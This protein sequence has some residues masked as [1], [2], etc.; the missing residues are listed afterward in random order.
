MRTKNRHN[1]LPGVLF[2]LTLL[3][4][5]IAQIH[6]QALTMPKNTFEVQ[7]PEPSQTPSPSVSEWTYQE[8]IKEGLALIEKN[9]PVLKVGV[10]DIIFY[11]RRIIQ[12]NGLVSIAKKQMHEPERD[13]ALV[14]LNTG[15][16]KLN[17]ITINE[18]GDKLS[19]PPGYKIAFVERTNGIKKNVWNTQRT[20]IEPSDTIVLLNVW[21][22]FVTKTVP[23]SIKTK[24]GKTK[25]IYET[26]KT[27]ENVVYSPYGDGLHVPEL[28]E[29]GREHRASD[30]QTAFDF[31]RKRGVMS[32]AFP[33]K[34]LA[35]VDVL[36]PE[37]FERLP[38]LEQT[39]Y[40]EFL[41]DP[42]KAL[43]R[44]DVIIGANGDNAYAPSCSHA[45]ACGYVQFTRGTYMAMDRKYPSARLMKDFETGAGDHI[46][47]TMAAILLFDY[48][49]VGY[50]DEFGQSILNDPDQLEEILD[51]SYNG[52]PVHAHRS[53]NA[54]ILQGLD[55]WITKYLRPETKGY[56]VKL[57]YIRDNY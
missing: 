5:L 45:G 39:D 32:R 27:V 24:N 9:K 14:L 22:H 25:T 42:K 55:D 50:L 40:A 34:L 21:P 56:M 51:S 1:L 46:N 53:L 3:T 15:T 37:F 41:F 19:P 16:G 36:R 33:S 52:N 31:L 57:R 26:K 30:V 18:K 35:D 2:F 7:G 38:L 23:R 29:A 12:N 4:L 17:M 11:E 43:E 13:V 28:I 6:A 48:N 47:S 20:V 8:K 49:L 54:S 10:N 44:V